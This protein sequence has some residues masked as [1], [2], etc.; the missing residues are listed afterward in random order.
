[1]KT[2]TLSYIIANLLFTFVALLNVVPAYAQDTHQYALYNYRND[3]EFNAWL[4]IDI[5]SITYSRIDT[6]GVEHEDVVVQEVWTPDS[7][8]RIPLEAIDSIGFRAPAPV[9]R[10]GIFFLRDYHAAH[11]LAIDSLTLYFD[12]SIPQD[13]L[14]SVG[15]T[16]LC[17]TSSTPYE[18]GFGGKVV[19]I[20]KRQDEIVITCE[21][22]AIGDIF[23]RLVLVGKVSSD[24][25]SDSEY[26]TNVRKSSD[27]WVNYE[28]HGVYPMN[29]EEKSMELFDGLFEVTSPHPKL[30]CTYYVY[31][32]ELF[33]EI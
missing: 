27:P 4:N 7:V 2:H 15:Q 32:N 8:Y 33:Y 9:M 3:G 24:I 25:E 21:E 18:E 5:D 26:N 1:M 16:I 10:D 6:L 31:V 13:S 23:Q 11:T 19:E 20:Q 14:P 28:E 22:I 29:L 17:V 12:A 30:T